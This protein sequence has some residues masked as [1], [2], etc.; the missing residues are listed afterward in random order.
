VLALIIEGGDLRCAA[1]PKKST[2]KIY[3]HFWLT[4][5]RLLLI[6]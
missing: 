2:T 4:L 3:E 5:S 6:K 1:T